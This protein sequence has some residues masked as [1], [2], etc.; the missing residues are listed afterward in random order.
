MVPTGVYPK[1]KTMEF[2][3]SGI[4]PTNCCPVV[5]APSATTL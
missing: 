5:G 4:D 2:V 1:F 3:P